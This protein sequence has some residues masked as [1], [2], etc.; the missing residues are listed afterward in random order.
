MSERYSMEQKLYRY[1]WVMVGIFWF[2][3]FAYG[4]NWFALS[5]MLKTFEADF[6]IASWESHLLI[7][8]I[9]MFVIFFAWPAGS[10]IDKKGP[11]ISI[12]IGAVFMAIGFGIRPWML[13]SFTMLM[14]SSIIAGIGLA[15]ILVAMAPQ[16][17]RWFPHTHAGLPVGIAASGLFIG[18]GTGSLVVPLIA[19]NATVPEDYYM[20]FLLFGIIA[21]IAFFIW[22]VVAKDHPETPPEERIQV[23]KMKFA[24]GMRQALTSKNAYVYPLIGFLIVGITLVI[25]AFLHQLYPGKDGGYIA[26]LLLYGCAI[27]AFFAPFVMK[28]IGLKKVTLSVIIGAILFWIIIFYLNI[29]SD[30]TWLLIVPVAFLFGVCFQASWPLALYCQ[31]TETGVSEANVG[32]AASLYISISNIGAAVLPVVFPIL[33]PDTFTNF[34]A[35]LVCL[36]ICLVLWGVIRRK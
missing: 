34:I 15:W 24:E 36:F 33:F 12:T 31:E 30:A 7:S 29:Y 35:I 5:P 32:I 17:L 26:G 10:L 1:R 27:G 3:I 11:K 16:I 21:V 8:L 14:G 2:L 9:G 19:P 25:S 6:G 20:S 22:V 23:E 13:D 28:K 18:F 4:A